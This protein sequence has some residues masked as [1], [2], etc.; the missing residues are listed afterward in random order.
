[1]DLGLL[2]Y[3]DYMDIDEEDNVVIRNIRERR[4]P[5]EIYTDG[6]FRERFGLAFAFF[7]FAFKSVHKICN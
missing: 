5:M 6:E 1:M 4:D 2:D 7:A 3:L